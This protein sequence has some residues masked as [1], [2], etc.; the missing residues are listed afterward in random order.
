MAQAHTY[1]PFPSTS[2]PGHSDS[3]VQLQQS[4]PSRVDAISPFV[5][6]LM[7]FIGS[8]R[9]A[10]GSELDIEI[11]LRE[12]LVNAVVHGNQ[13]NPRKRVYV[14]CRCSMDGALSITVQDQGQGFDIHAMPDP[15]APDNRLSAHGRGI[16]LMRAFMDEVRFE[17]GGT[18]VHMRKKSNARATRPRANREVLCASQDEH[19]INSR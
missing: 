15:T 12:A 17:E 2:P 18:V 19:T 8:V 16:Y 14:V 3:L 6:Q 11:A 5:D 4:F 1:V 10:D 7:C 13:G 9:T